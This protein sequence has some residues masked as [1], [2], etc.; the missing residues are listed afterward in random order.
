M[1][2]SYLV[3][4]QLRAFIDLVIVLSVFLSSFKLVIV[5]GLVE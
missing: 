4:S 5:C 3:V 2:P 1:I